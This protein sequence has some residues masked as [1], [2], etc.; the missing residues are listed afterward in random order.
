MDV[1]NTDLKNLRKVSYLDLYT[2]YLKELFNNNIFV[3]CKL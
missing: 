3:L 2:Q 1:I